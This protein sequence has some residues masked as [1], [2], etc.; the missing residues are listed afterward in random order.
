MNVSGRKSMNRIILSGMVALCALVFSG[1]DAGDLA[2]VPDEETLSA[3]ALT[4]F[5]Q[6]LQEGNYERAVELYG[7][8]YTALE[9]YN[10]DLDPQDRAKLLAKA[11]QVNGFVCLSVGEV[12]AIQSGPNETYNVSVTFLD[13]DGT[14]FVREGC[15]GE[16]SENVEPQSI[17]TFEVKK[18][19]VE[20]WRVMNLPVYI[21]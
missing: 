11:C 19:A 16:S 10:P 20:R 21:P 4:D 12:V 5:F 17:F 7:G 18:E 8:P 2:P 15:C 13:E 6:A 1:C 14:L 3:S 9:E